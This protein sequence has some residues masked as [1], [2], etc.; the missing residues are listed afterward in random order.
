MR[1]REIDSIDWQQLWLNEIQHTP[2][3]NHTPINWDEHAQDFE[4][5]YSHSDYVDKMLE[6]IDVAPGDTILETGCGPGNLAI[7]LSQKASAVTAIDLSGEMVRLASSAAYS[8]N[9]TNIDFRQQDWQTLIPGTDIQPHD[10][11]VCSRAFSTTHPVDSLALLN[12]LAKKQVYLTLKTIEDG[13][14][15]FYRRLYKQIGKEYSVAPDYIYAYNLLYQMGIS[16]CVSF[17]D[18]TDSFHISS[19]AEALRMLNSHIQVETLAQKEKLLD[20]ISEKMQ[21]KSFF[22]LNIKCRWAL[23]S[24]HK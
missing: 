3:G 16:A 14:E 7:P 4:R 6:R 11:V 19:A 10:I 2:K 24:W 5:Y 13:A 21:D 18:Y 1:N 17:I 9:I 8:K 23:L 15:Y 12:S 20:F 22:K